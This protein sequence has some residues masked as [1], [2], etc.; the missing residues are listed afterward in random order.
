MITVIDKGQKVKTLKCADL[1]KGK[2]Y[3]IVNS[4]S[5]MNKDY[6]GSIGI[7]GC[8]TS[9]QFTFTNITVSPGM[10]W[11]IGDCG[12][13][14]VEFCEVDLEITVKWNNSV[15]NRVES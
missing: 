10:S 7:V 15:K 2:A 3:R 13:F 12:E 4:N 1:E 6:I 9:Y 14:A 8:G 11:N 5:S